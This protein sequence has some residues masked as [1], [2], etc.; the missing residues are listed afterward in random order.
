MQVIIILLAAIL[1]TLLG[2][3]LL[4]GA[5]I[6]FPIYLLTLIPGWVWA[7]LGIAVVLFSVW[8]YCASEDQLQIPTLETNPRAYEK[9]NR[10]ILRKLNADEE[11]SESD[12]EFLRADPTYHGPLPPRD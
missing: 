9:R 10:E 4:V 7:M 1:I 5:L 8:A 6:L 3:W 11:L 2:G 12:Y